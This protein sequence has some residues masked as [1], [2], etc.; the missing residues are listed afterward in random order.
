MTVRAWL[1]MGAL[2]GLAC[3][4]SKETSER[5][6]PP[7]GQ[8]VDGDRASLA[9]FEA[10]FRPSTYDDEVELVDRG[11]RSDTS[12]FDNNE[13]TD[14]VHIEER[15]VQGFRIQLLATPHFDEV[16][17]A[18]QVAA[19]LFETDSVYV[20]FD[21]PIYKLRVGDYRSRLDANRALSGV[22]RQGYPDAWVVADRVVQRTV[23]RT[24][25]NGRE[26]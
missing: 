15:F 6:T 13:E 16:S 7:N 12:G 9:A 1:L 22:I 14:S 10:S 20:V 25:R 18:R 24:P 11:Q 17:Q 19:Q 21:P 8:W 5:E 23:V 2:A 3:G 4:A 26:E